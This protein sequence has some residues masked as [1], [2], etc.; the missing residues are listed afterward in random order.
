MTLEIPPMG[1]LVNE[2]KPQ[3]YPLSNPS[4][5]L[6][7]PQASEQNPTLLEVGMKNRKISQ[8]SFLFFFRQ[9]PWAA[10]PRQLTSCSGCKQQEDWSRDP[11][12]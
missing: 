6:V 3:S 7:Y 12:Q 4:S 11:I 10:W 8:L 9:M 1:P 2:E 5:A